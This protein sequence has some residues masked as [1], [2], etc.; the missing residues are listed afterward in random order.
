MSNIVSINKN[1]FSVSTPGGSAV[2]PD[3]I[4]LIL[5]IEDSFFGTFADVKWMDG[6][7]EGHEERVM[8]SSI[9]HEVKGCGVYYA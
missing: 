5:N 4:G 9:K 2:N 3:S 1:V 6:V 8:L 7:K